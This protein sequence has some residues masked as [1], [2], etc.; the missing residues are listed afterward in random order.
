VFCIGCGGENADTA[1]SSKPKSV[2]HL[3]DAERDYMDGAV[4]NSSIVLYC[5]PEGE[6]YEQWTSDSFSSYIYDEHGA[7]IQENIEYNGSNKMDSVLYLYDH[8]GQVAAKQ[9]ERLA[10]DGQRQLYLTIAFT[11]DND[12][13]IISETHVA[14]YTT[15]IQGEVV[16]QDTLLATIDYIY[17]YK[18]SS[19]SELILMEKRA[20]SDDGEVRVYFRYDDANEKIVSIEYDWD[21]DFSIDAIMYVTHDPAGNREVDEIYDYDIFGNESLRLTVFYTWESISSSPNRSTYSNSGL[22]LGLGG[23]PYY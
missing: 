11:Y 4:R 17:A 15:G 13:H 6:M 3:A 23:G 5:N 1:G 7:L 2:F 8:Q 16:V 22:A 18:D 14:P 12:G 21:N 19:Q 20:L 10:E 9:Y